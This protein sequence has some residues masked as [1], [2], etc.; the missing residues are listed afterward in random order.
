[1][2]PPNEFTPKRDSQQVL[3][4]EPATADA[5]ARE[6]PAM[7]SPDGGPMGAG[8]PAAAGPVEAIPVP[9]VLVLGWLPEPVCAGR[10]VLC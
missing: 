8:Q 2:T 9:D 5:T 4:A 10:V 1:M 3:K 7:R 6:T